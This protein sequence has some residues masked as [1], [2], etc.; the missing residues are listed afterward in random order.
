M[1][2]H[3]QYG[4]CVIGVRSLL[5]GYFAR[6]ELEAEGAGQES[7]RGSIDSNDTWESE[8]SI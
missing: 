7:P 3:T 8:Q 1:S 2:E 5:S 6:V 4:D